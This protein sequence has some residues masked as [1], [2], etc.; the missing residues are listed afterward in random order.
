MFPCFLEWLRRV[1]IAI[2][3]SP[4]QTTHTM[5]WAGL[6]FKDLVNRNRFEVSVHSNASSRN[7][8]LTTYLRVLVGVK[9]SRRL[10]G[11][12]PAPLYCQ[13]VGVMPGSGKTSEE[14]KIGTVA[15]ISTQ[16]QFQH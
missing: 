16:V 7:K 12:N 15:T 11:E 4:C 10:V 1:S 5:S 14:I 3:A 2:S 8:D 13:N 6:G 9:S